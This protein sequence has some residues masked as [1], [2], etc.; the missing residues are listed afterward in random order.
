MFK[1]IMN[2]V[3]KKNKT[4]TKTRNENSN[5]HI[6]DGNDRIIELVSTSCQIY[7]LY[8]YANF[9]YFWNVYKRYGSS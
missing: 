9:K 2:F 8:F 1:N 6:F 5:N 3:K 4:L 7:W